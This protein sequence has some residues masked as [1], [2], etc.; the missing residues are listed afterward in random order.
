M[1]T[2]QIVSEKLLAYLDDQLSFDQIVAWAER[3]IADGN[4]TPDSHIDSLINIVT[5][6]VDDPKRTS[7]RSQLMNRPEM[8]VMLVPQDAA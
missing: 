6:L 3:V 1:I 5:C 8:A 4:F 2:Q 7:A